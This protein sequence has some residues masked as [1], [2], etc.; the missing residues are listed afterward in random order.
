M[1]KLLP[2]VLG[3]F[4]LGMDAYVVAGLMPAIGAGLRVSTFAIGLLVTAFTLAYALLSPIGAALG[5]ALPARVVLLGA[6]GV[7]T[8]GMR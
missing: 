2:L 3:A 5:A 6:L 1:R 4:A 8:V 7:F